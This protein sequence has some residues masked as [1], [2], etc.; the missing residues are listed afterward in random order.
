MHWWWHCFLP[1]TVPHC[2][3][4]HCFHRRNKSKRVYRKKL[5]IV[6]IQ[7]IP[8]LSLF[9]LKRDRRSAPTPMVIRSSSQRTSPLP[10]GWI[11]VCYGVYISTVATP[12]RADDD[13]SSY[14]NYYDGSDDGVCMIYDKNDFFTV[15]VQMALALA[16]IASLW[17][18][19]LR[20][21]PQRTFRTWFLDVSKQGLGACYAHVMNMCIATIISEN[22]RGDNV[23]EDQCAWYGLSYLIDTTLGLLLAIIGLQSLERMANQYDWAPLKH[24][25]VYYGETALYHWTCQVFAWILI[26]T[27]TK[28]IIYLFMW[29]FSN[30]LAWIGSTLFAPFSGYKHFELL[31]VMIF[32]PGVLNVIY[33]WIADSYLKASSDQ[34]EAHEHDETGLEDKKESLISTTE[35]EMIAKPTTNASP[36]TWS[37][38]SATATAAV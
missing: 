30:P 37:A 1:P 15:G 5:P 8:V 24:S 16:A 36:P 7:Y 28:F 18:K 31:F 13:S 32:F 23:L 38:L 22:I 14:S 29:I 21:H 9:S 17:W 3:L 4:I 12:A 19:R 34:A 11:L 2:E 35:A 20:E 25:G 33:F 10:V 26:L 6:S 27:V